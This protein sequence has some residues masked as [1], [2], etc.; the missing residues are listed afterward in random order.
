MT[1]HHQESIVIPAGGQVKF[2]PGGLPVMLT[3]LGRD[4]KVGDAFSLT[5]RFQ[6]AGE[7]TL[8]VKVREP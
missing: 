7:R 6:S 1:M 8:Q 2:E 5:L 3:N 4:L